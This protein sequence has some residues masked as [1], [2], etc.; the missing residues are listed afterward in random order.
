MTERSAAPEA[1]GLAPAGTPTGILA[2]GDAPPG[3]EAAPAPARARRRRFSLQ[4]AVTVL[5][6]VASAAALYG[7]RRYGMGAG[8]TFAG[9]PIDYPLDKPAHSTADQQRILS[10]LERR[11]MVDQVP[12]EELHKNPF[13]LETGDAAP[14][15]TEV[16]DDGSA[17]ARR[18]SEAA[19]QARAARTAQVEQAFGALRLNSIMMGATPLARIGEELVREGDT[20]AGLFTV[21]KIL[22]RSVELRADGVTYTLVLGERP[23]G[24]PAKKRKP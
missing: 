5:V 15:P 1:Q 23:G 24:A 2:P 22:E 12:P 6:V 21:A 11:G 20:V 19:E 7:M 9:V 4:T 14:P 13:A 8:M 10:T 17:A 3:V 18:A 16:P